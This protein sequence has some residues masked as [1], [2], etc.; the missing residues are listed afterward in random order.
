MTAGPRSRSRIWMLG[1][2]AV[3]GVAFVAGVLLVL[4]AK[5]ATSGAGWR[6]DGL[7]NEVIHSL[8]VGHTHPTLLFAGAGDGVYRRGVGGKWKRVLATE[9]AWAV[10]LLPD[11]RTVVAGDEAGC[12]DIST[13]SGRRWRK[14]LV[15]SGGIFALT[16]KPGDEQVILAGGGGGLFLSRDG[17]RHWQRRLALPR[18]AGAAFAW[19]GQSRS[20]VFA[21][22]ISGA[23]GGST[24][25]YES[26]DAGLHW[27]LFGRGLPSLGGI[28]SL[29]VIAPGSVLVGTMG[30]RIWQRGLS[31]GSWREI[32]RGIPARQHVAAIAQVPGSPA[33][34]F[35]GTLAD[36]V[37]E[38][39]DGGRHWNGR[40]DG[41]PGGAGGQIVLSLAYMRQQRVLYAGTTEGVYRLRG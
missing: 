32:A 14:T 20:T 4:R 16:V 12:V 23:P 33:R 19:L 22:A 9:T 13:D 2:V 28:M 29:A 39:T 36:G 10:T 40:S 34:L 1:A 41:L 17:G 11:D 37:F 21:G 3:L 8:A 15:S 18:S 27:R 7:P 30:N 35:I 25:V 31:V 26:R 5:D 38:S 6:V 24:Q